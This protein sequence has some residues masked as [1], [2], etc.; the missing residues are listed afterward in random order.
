MLNGKSRKFTLRASL[1][2]VIAAGL[3]C[4]TLTLRA[5]DEAALRHAITKGTAWLLGGQAPDGS[6]PGT[7][8]F[9]ATAKGVPTIIAHSG[10][11]TAL[12]MEALFAMGHRPRDA[13]PPGEALDAATSWLLGFLERFSAGSEGQSCAGHADWSRMYGHGMMTLAL[14]QAA[15]YEPDA[16]RK[17]RMLAWLSGGL[18]VILDAQSVKKADIAQ[19][20]WRYEPRS[21][22]SDISV[23]LWQ[24]KA[25]DACRL[26]GLEVPE[27]AFSSARAYILR[28]FQDGSGR[29][30]QEYRARP[31]DPTEIAPR[32][33]EQAKGFSYEPYGGR[34]TFSTS[35]AGLRALQLCAGKDCPQAGVVAGELIRSLPN[36]DEPWYFYALPNLAEALIEQEAALV[37]SLEGGFVQKIL[38]SQSADGAWRPRNGNE[39]AA[40]EVYATALALRTLGVL[41]DALFGKKK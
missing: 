30:P 4:C 41:Q 27:Q 40:G 14:A 33:G 6:F 39:K 28:S 22:D 32:K 23:T 37:R 26:A 15:N 25:L 35:A 16:A 21:A 2:H 34:L 8:P 17:Q 29:K 5:A 1:L 19:G 9:R 7:P 20:G 36:V 12:V 18:K 10:A 31:L 11:N 3:A 13:S 24:V 38:G